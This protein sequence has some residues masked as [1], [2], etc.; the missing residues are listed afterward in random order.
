MGRV[1]ASDE[2][3][4]CEEVGRGG[5][6]VVYRGIVKKSGSEVAVK[7]IDLE[8]EQADMFDINKEIQILSECRL[9]QITRYLGCFVK[10]YK[11]WVVMEYVDGGSLYDLLKPGPIEDDLTVAVISHE[12]L[13]ALHY[14]HSQGTIHRDL[15][16]QNIL[17]G[18][19]GEVKLTDFGVSTQLHSNFSRR[20]TT[21]GTPYWMAPEVILNNAGGHGY[22]ADVWSFGCC[23]YE[24]RHGTPP[25]QDH[26]AP[27]K[28]LRRI[29]SCKTTEDFVE[30]IGLRQQKW[31][32][33]LTDM[34]VRCFSV[35]T[36]MRTT[37]AKLLDHKYVAKAAIPEEARRKLLKKIVTRKHLWDQ[38][39]HVVRTQRYYSPTEMVA[40]QNKWQGVVEANS[41]HFD[42]SFD[43]MDNGAE[44]SQ[45]EADQKQQ[46]VGNGKHARSEVHARL[47]SKDFQQTPNK[48]TKDVLVLPA[49]STVCSQDS[50]HDRAMKG[51]LV[52]ILNR[53]FYRMDQK[54]ALVTD[55]YDDLV[56]LND[57]LI[58]LF[59]PV[60][61][62][63]GSRILICQYFKYL[64][65]ELARPT[66]DGARSMLQ[67]AIIPSSFSDE[68][69]E[70]E[71]RALDEK[72]SERREMDMKNG[73]MHDIARSLMESWLEKME[74]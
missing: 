56:A 69:R 27:M 16:S 26:Y 70:A 14:L 24:L 44:E 39:N 71:R 29:S 40:N 66:H 48:L 47:N 73:P 30:L 18:R 60:H 11:L 46:D 23:I 53:V 43:D 45:K 10:G 67:R 19:S 54:A 17:I 28:A 2:L 35:D 9:P 59:T 65:K 74:R 36:R 49:A 13:V 72:E 61:F 32:D 58:R 3:E 55:Q 8:N 12:I 1:Q 64:L 21:V 7:Q 34:L 15:K 25:L 50:V 33:L 31:P 52:K 5:F 41:V 37:V 38:E 6:G 51:E 68:K 22:K 62:S 20:N 42:I 63:S 4:L 57:K